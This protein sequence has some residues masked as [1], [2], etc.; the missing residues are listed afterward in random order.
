MYKTNQKIPLKDLVHKCTIDVKEKMTVA[1]VILA[2]MAS[3]LFGTRNHGRSTGE[4]GSYP[5]NLLVSCTVTTAIVWFVI[6]HALD[7]LFV[8]IGAF[9]GYMFYNKIKHNRLIDP[10]FEHRIEN[11]K[12]ACVNYY[13]DHCQHLHRMEYS[14]SACDRNAECIKTVAPT[15]EI[16]EKEITS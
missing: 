6:H 15:S 2:A 5:G 16:G 3:V 4:M 12:A 8:M 9:I 1:I 11:A 7:M 14:R 13:K 10:L